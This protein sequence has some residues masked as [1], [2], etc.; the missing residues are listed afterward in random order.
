VDFAAQLAGC[1]VAGCIP[2]SQFQRQEKCMRV[3][4]TS[5]PQSQIEAPK[6][7]EKKDIIG[8]DA[9]NNTAMDESPSFVPFSLGSGRTYSLSSLK[10]AVER[11]AK[12]LT[13]A[14]SN[15]TAVH[16]A[17]SIPKGILDRLNCR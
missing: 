3:E 7:I 9:G 11:H 1:G 12:F 10:A 2:E 5:I 17:V 15:L 16:H 13:V 4:L 8:G 6:T 14:E